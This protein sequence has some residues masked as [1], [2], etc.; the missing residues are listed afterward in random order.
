MLEPRRPS[1]PQHR[2]LAWRR[3]LVVATLVIGFVSAPR[4]GQAEAAPE[5]LN[6]YYDLFQKDQ[7]VFSA[8]KTEMRADLAP[9]VVTVIPQTAL[10]AR[11]YRTIG[12]ALASVPGLFVL[13]DL[14]TS[15]VSVRG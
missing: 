10:A 6:Y 3:R 14:V 15:N 2:C 9:A 11:G 7:R 1:L 12:E 5:V 8:S 4:L 13:D